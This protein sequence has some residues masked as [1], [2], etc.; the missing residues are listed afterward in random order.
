[1]RLT[2]T[3]FILFFGCS[4]NCATSIIDLHRSCPKC[5]YELCLSCCKEIRNGSIIPHSEMKFQY[6]DRG[7]DYMH[8]GDGDPL[9]AVS[10]DFDTSESNVVIFTKWNPN[11]D[12][13]VECA[14]KEFGGCGGGCVLELKR[15]LPK[16]KISDLVNKASNML[17]HFCNN[18]QMKV[19]KEEVSSSMIRAAF[20]DGKN[21]NNI[22]CP[23]SSD[24]VKGGL[25]EFQKHWRNGEPIIVRDVLKQGTGLSWEPMVT[26]RALCGN[27]VSGVSSNFMSQ[28]KAIDCLASCEVCFLW[29][30]LVL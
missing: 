11:S 12:G 26:W 20:R 13:S 18:E 17:K 14:P 6:V 29:L 27:L 2:N 8:G 19:H 7:Y 10:C 21:D 22:Y 4:D 23:V 15:M 9:Q 1:M 5:S 28:V 16:G 25:F 30:L 24:L 3:N